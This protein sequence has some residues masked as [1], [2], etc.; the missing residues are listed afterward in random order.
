MLT[1][2]DIIETGQNASEDLLPKKSILLYQSKY[3]L[4]IDWCYNKIITKDSA[5]LAYFSGEWTNLKPT[6]ARSSLSMLKST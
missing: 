5:V 1:P 6:N 2:P 3:E 4:F